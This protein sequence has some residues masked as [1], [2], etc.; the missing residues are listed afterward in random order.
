MVERTG[1]ENQYTPKGIRGSN[2]LASATENYDGFI[3]KFKCWDGNKFFFNTFNF[4]LGFALERS[5]FMEVSQE[6]PQKMVC[7]FVSF[8]HLSH[9]GN[10]LHFLFFKTKT[11]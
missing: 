7:C 6:W 1:L 11:C 10:H 2:P 3:F 9:F 8:K 5:G 4:T